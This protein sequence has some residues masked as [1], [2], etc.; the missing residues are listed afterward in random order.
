MADTHSGADGRVIGQRGRDMQRRSRLVSPE[1]DDAAVAQSLGI[2]P[3]DARRS[4]EEVDADMRSARSR[5]ESS[6]S[7]DINQ[8]RRSRMLASP[9]PPP[10]V[11][12]RS[13]QRHMTESGGDVSLKVFYFFL[14]HAQAATSYQRGREGGTCR[15]SR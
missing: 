11:R 6:F 2:L 1:F 7:S 8:T 5:S 12:G 13:P 4:K 3:R 9:S 14:G 10:P 15:V